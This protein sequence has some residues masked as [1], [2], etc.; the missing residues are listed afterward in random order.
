MPAKRKSQRGGGLRDIVQYVRDNKLISKGLG[1]IPHP[2][3]QVAS[4]V[5]GMLGLGRKRKRKSMRGRGI[6]SDI[7]GGL[8]NLANGVGHGL[9]GSGRK[10]KP[11]KSLL[12][13]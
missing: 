3:A 6:F 7:G 1:I 9:F 12:K 2:T 8:G 11:K 13:M 10:R 4:K 5:A